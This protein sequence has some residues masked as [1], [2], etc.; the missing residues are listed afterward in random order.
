[1]SED[2]LDLLDLLALGD[3]G[4]PAHLATAHRA[5]EREH[6]VD[7]GDQ[8]R[9]PVVRWALGWH[10][11]PLRHHPWYARA[12]LRRLRRGRLGRRCHSHGH[13]RS[14]ERRIRTQHTKIAVPVGA[15]RRHQGG[16]AVYQLQRRGV[17]L[18]HLGSTLVRA[19]LAALFG[20]A[21]T[22]ECMPGLE[23]FGNG[24]VEQR[25]LGVA[26][27]VEFGRGLRG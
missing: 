5:Q 8:H 24:L 4:D 26:H 14:P 19:R 23:V 3:K 11:V 12:S 2:L 16:N 10:C 27:L 20:L 15:W 13:H 9:P 18:V 22:G 6:L 17:Q 1:M 7:S 25:A 21:F